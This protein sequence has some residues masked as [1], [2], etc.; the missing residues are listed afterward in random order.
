ML[1]DHIVQCD[2]KEA[3]PNQ[4]QISGIDQNNVDMHLG[5][6]IPLESR[7]TLQA[8]LQSKFVAKPEVDIKSPMAALGTMPLSVAVRDKRF[9][10]YIGLILFFMVFGIVGSVL[11]RGGFTGTREFDQS[12]FPGLIGTSLLLALL[13]KLTQPAGADSIGPPLVRITSSRNWFTA[14][15][16]AAAAWGVH[17]IGTTFGVTSVP[18]SYVAGFA[19][20]GMASIFI[21]ALV[22]QPVDLRAKGIYRFGGVYWPWN[23]VRLIAWQPVAGTLVLQR[24]WRTLRAYVSAEQCELVDNVLREKLGG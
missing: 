2:Y 13:R 16:A 8:I 23:E 7:D 1:W 11:F 3:A 18:V 21:Q 20:G 6:V 14:L 12:I 19:F 5:V 24:G 17:W 10:K 9:L 15:A 22:R 4:L